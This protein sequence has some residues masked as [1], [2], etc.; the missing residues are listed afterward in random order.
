MSPTAEGEKAPSEVPS[1][2]PSVSPSSSPSSTP[3]RPIDLGAA[4]NYAILAESGI[5]TVPT[6][7]VTGDIGVSPIAATAIT[8][9]SLVMDEASGQFST[10]SQVTGRC[11]AASYGGAT[12]ADLTTSINNMHAAYTSAAGQASTDTTKDNMDDGAIGGKTLTPGVYTFT[13]GVNIMSD[14]T[15]EGGAN[16]FFL[17]KTT[18]VLTQAANTKV[19][20][21]GGAQAKNVFWQVAGNAAIGADAAMKGILLVKTDVVFVTGSSLVGSVLAQTA[22]NLQKATITQAAGTCTA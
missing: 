19:L 11:F 7:A 10:S 15:F 16:D 22:V 4:C 13:V 6:S 9:F 12:A 3:G 21:S 14:L 5:D 18:G 1:S 20:L 17:I 8:G 2:S